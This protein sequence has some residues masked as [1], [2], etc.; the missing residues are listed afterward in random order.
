MIYKAKVKKKRKLSRKGSLKKQRDRKKKEGA[1][2]T[3][4]Q[5]SKKQMHV[6]IRPN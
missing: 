1:Q 3:G 4:N 2:S 6:L 5:N